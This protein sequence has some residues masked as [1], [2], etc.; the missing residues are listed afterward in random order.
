MGRKH[1]F[2]SSYQT[3]SFKHSHIQDLWRYPYLWPDHFFRKVPIKVV[4]NNSYQCP[5]IPSRDQICRPEDVWRLKLVVP[6]VMAWPE[7]ARSRMAQALWTPTP[8]PLRRGSAW[9]LMTHPQNN[10][11]RPEHFIFLLPGNENEIRYSR[12]TNIHCKESVI[13]KS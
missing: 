7:A 2:I 12:A 13:P 1:K 6:L 5:I 9:R 11:N 8:F 4:L 10:K 3:W